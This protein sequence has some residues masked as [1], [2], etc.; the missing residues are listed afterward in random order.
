VEL[1]NGSGV[2]V[3]EYPYKAGRDIL[4]VKCNLS[5]KDEFW[6]LRILRADENLRYRI[7]GDAIP[8]VSQSKKSVLSHSR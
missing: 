5:D 2:K 3:A 6:C 8:V 7:G 4:T 1:L